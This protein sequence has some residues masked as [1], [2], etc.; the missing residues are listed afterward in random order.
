MS[1]T[2][3]T[4]DESFSGDPAVPSQDLVTAVSD[5]HLV[6]RRKSR[7]GLFLRGGGGRDGGGGSRPCIHSGACRR[8]RRRCGSRAMHRLSSSATGSRAAISRTTFRAS[9][10]NATR[11][12]IVTPHQE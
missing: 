9:R 3:T 11:P 4:L 12:G 10:A 5:H 7:P 6:G 1:V 2:P 8:S